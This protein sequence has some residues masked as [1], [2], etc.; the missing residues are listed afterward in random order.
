MQ[1]W[2]PKSQFSHNLLPL[3][4]H[5][6]SWVTHCWFSAPVKHDYAINQS[7]CSCLSILPHL[8]YNRVDCGTECWHFLKNPLEAESTHARITQRQLILS[9]LDTAALLSNKMLI[10]MSIT[11]LV[12]R[13]LSQHLPIHLVSQEE[14]ANALVEH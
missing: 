10:L 2:K 13:L 6:P 14:M 4:L 9:P 11:S 5:F 8:G 7:H 1:F 3:D 12:I